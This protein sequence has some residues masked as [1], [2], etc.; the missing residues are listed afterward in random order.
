[1]PSDKTAT[2][3]LIHIHTQTHTRVL[4]LRSACWSATASTIR[5][6][7]CKVVVCGANR[8]RKRAGTLHGEFHQVHGW[9]HEYNKTRV[10]A[11][12]SARARL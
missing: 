3:A 7:Y 12:W 5:A 8:E 11:R 1:M 9:S 4:K 6:V 2:Y 10:R